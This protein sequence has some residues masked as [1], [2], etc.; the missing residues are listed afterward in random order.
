MNVSLGNFPTTRLRRLRQ[1]AWSRDLVAE[2]LL[3]PRDLIL[4][5]FVRE[6]EIAPFVSQLPDVKRL[7]LEELGPLCAQALS[8]GIP[9]VALFPVVALA[10]RTPNAD[11]ILNPQGL[12]IQ[13]IQLLKRELPTLGVITDV[14][15]D[16]FTSHGQDG[17]MRDN[18]IL[19]DETL[20]ILG[21]AAVLQA[22]AGSDVIAPSD[23]M[24]GRVRVIRTALDQAGFDQVQIMS[25]TAKYA[26]S[27]YAPFRQALGSASCLGKGD[28]K[29]Y[30]ID[31][32]NGDEALR[33]AATD[34]MEGADMLI[35]K[36]GL[37]YLDVL[38]R[39]HKEFP[40]PLAAYQVTG[41][42]AMLKAASQN[43]W[44]DGS[45]VL[46]ESLIAFKRAGAKAILTYGAL[47]AARLLRG[48]SV[49]F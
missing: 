37:P 33:E 8:L 35:V 21:P 42:Y 12:L 31:P 39:L 17:L 36:P 48:E 45:Q 6:P 11:E 25:Y 18:L 7:T 40:V 38:Y 34:L 32:R 22:Q 26:S 1:T 3:T 13:A 19:N 43:G 41:E 14:A 5:L 23:M 49:S 46:L 4:P 9:A 30:Y 2:H 47:E 44:L 20:A 16:A 15:L 27:F 24:D 28:K 10:K 29:T